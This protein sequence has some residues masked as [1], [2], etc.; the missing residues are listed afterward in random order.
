MAQN[1]SFTEPKN[2]S[3]DSVSSSTVLFNYR[4]YMCCILLG[5]G[6]ERIVD[7]VPGGKA[8]ELQLRRGVGQAAHTRS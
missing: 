2:G 6:G 7:T 8:L 3:Q 5:R 4:M 1:K